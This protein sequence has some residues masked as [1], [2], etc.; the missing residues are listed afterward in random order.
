MAARRLEL[1]VPP[2]DEY[3]DEPGT[4][5]AYQE[6]TPEDSPAPCTP[7]L[8]ALAGHASHF[9]LD[10]FNRAASVSRSGKFARLFSSARKSP[11]TPGGGSVAASPARSVESGSGAGGVT[12]SSAPSLSLDDM[13]V[14]QN[15]CIPTSLLKLSTENS[16]RAVKIFAAVQRYMGD[17]G[18]GPAPTGAAKLELVVKL[19]SQGIKKA[20]LK[21]ELYMQ[22]L[23]QSRGNCTVSSALSWELF[24]LVA[25]AMPP[26]KDFVGLVSEY[27]HTVA[28]GDT[29][30]DATSRALAQRTWLALK[31]SAKAGVR[32]TVPGPEEIEAL[33]AGRKQTTIVFFLDETFE[34][35]E[36]DATTTV[37]E[38]VEFL[39]R[40]IKL[41]NFTT[42]TLYECRKTLKPELGQAASDEHFLLEDNKYIADVLADFREHKS[43]DTQSKVLFKKRMFRETDETITEP[44]FV[45]LS[46]VQAQHDYLSGNYPVVREDA[47]QMCALQMQAE[48]GPTM[49]E[50]L[51]MLEGAIERFV[52]K[53]VLMTRPREEWKVDVLSRYKA[54]EQFSKEDARLQFLRIL[55][56]LPYGNSIFFNVKRIEDPIGLLPAKLILGINKRGVHFFRPV[57]KEYLHSAELR[58]IMQF[59]SSSQAVF[60]KMR[61]A[62]VLH[63]F[64]F[65]TRQGEDICMAL[66]THINDIMMKRYSKAKQ[67][68]GGEGTAHSGTDAP[69]ANFGPK[70][71]AHLADLHKQLEE[72]TQT[73]AAM[74]R[75][76]AQLHSERARVAEDLEEAQERLAAEV[77]AQKAGSERLDGALREGE[78]LRVELNALRQNLEKAEGDKTRAVEAAVSAAVAE[79]PARAQEEAPAAGVAMRAAADAQHLRELE[80][81]VTSLQGQLATATSALH[82]AEAALREAQKEGELAEKRMQRLEAARLSEVGSLSKELDTLRASADAD[83]RARDVKLNGLVEELGNTQALLSEKESELA[84]VAGATAEL[85]ELREMKEDVERRE[86][87]QAAV[88]E[89]QAKRLEELETLYKDESIMRKKY[90]NQM[91]D[92][93]GKIR[94]YARVRPMLGFEAER[95]QKVALNIPDELTLDHIWKDKKRE[96]SFD[97]VFA[98][99]TSQEKVFEDTRHLV[100]SAV[101]GYNVCIF[102]YGQT[103]SGKTHTIYGGDADAGLTPRGINE[104]FAILDRDGGKYTFSVSCYML[105]LYQDDLA[106]LLLPQNG[107]ARASQASRNSNGGGAATAFGGAQARAPRL[108]IKKDTKGMVSV[109]GATI[110]EVT[111]ARELLAAID[112]GQQRRHVSST[113]MNRESSRSHLVMSVIIEATNLQTQNVT[114]GKLSFVDLAGSERVKKSGSTGEQ[115]KEAQAIN[116]SLSA[117]GDVISALATEQPHIPYRNHKLTMLMSDSLGGTAKTLMF[118][119]VSPTD[120][121]LDETQNSLA[122]ATRVRTIKNNV[123]KNEANKEILKLRKQIDF[124]KEQA[125]LSPEQRAYVELEDI[126]DERQRTDSSD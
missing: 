19:L 28:H 83:A 124:W 77:A 115:L 60:F 46:Y 126:T 75:N 99:G 106:D 24:Y 110:V 109:P 65:D 98:P 6:Q 13:L 117:L 119:N 94:V 79:A 32:S 1:D 55:R 70:Y 111:S 123:T 89:N 73:I 33:L 3:M 15:E 62:G 102:A 92:M 58:D 4:P 37:L 64:Q 36:Y 44:Q 38:A 43:R 103:G 41:Q 118:V 18:D 72:A 45:T 116:K 52:T 108:E 104:L 63:I 71:E 100:Q 93:K 68:A 125:G 31:R 84:A 122:Y 112:A 11:K 56:S 9:Q 26:S 23:K 34:E 85:E 27:V 113:Q 59:G 14:Y 29:D 88:I 25:S 67:M 16:T 35:L 80:D 50:T 69:A 47:A 87:A 8:E 17:A 5:P 121:N 40:V 2:A 30:V 95:G 39:A 54:L 82:T 66:Q 96:Y 49:L 97:A 120:T 90:F 53:Q 48:A 61:V 76:E 78:A 20:E 10:S 12:P 42:F 101:D 51:E 81:K 114:K 21:D 86:R 107:Q 74:K 105:E 7:H 22:L 91:E 57:P